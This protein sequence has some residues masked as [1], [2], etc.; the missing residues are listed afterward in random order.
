[1]QIKKFDFLNPSYGRIPL[2]SC[3]I[4]GQSI[5]FHL[6]QK[7]FLVSYFLIARRI[8]IIIVAIQKNG[9]FS[10]KVRRNCRDQ[11]CS[12][13]GSNTTDN[14]DAAHDIC[15]DITWSNF[16]KFSNKRKKKWGR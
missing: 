1:M 12:K 13:V 14:E 10:S 15:G 16:Q 7:N 5:Y 2:I 6:L 9:L 4:S 3:L 8:I 11:S